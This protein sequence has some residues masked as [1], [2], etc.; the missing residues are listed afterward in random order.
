MSE[1]R[2]SPSWENAEGSDTNHSALPHNAYGRLPGSQAQHIGSGESFDL[3]GVPPTPTKSNSPPRSSVESL[4]RQFGSK[5]RDS[6]LPVTSEMPDN[7]TLDSATLVEAGFDESVLRALCDLDCGIPLLL[8]RIKQS[9]VS[10]R[11]RICL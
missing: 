8:D 4:T 5:W 3:N 6:M 11:V 10:C 2:Y 1:E 7:G 9:M